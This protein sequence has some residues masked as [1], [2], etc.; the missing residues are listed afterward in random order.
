MNAGMNDFVAKPFDPKDLEAVLEK[1][2]AREAF[3]AAS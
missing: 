2:C 3:E 1:W